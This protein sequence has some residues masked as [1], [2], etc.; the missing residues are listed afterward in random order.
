MLREV[1]LNSIYVIQSLP[2][3]ETQTGSQLINDTIERRAYHFKYLKSA[4]IEV[5]SKEDLI[6]DLNKW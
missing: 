4:L 2:D 5:I 6:N 1:L 3:T